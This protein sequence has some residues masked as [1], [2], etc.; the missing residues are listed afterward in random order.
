MTY[1]EHIL[2][3]SLAKFVNRIYYTKQDQPFKRQKVFPSPYI[4]LTFNLGEP[5]KFFEDGG[6][7]Q[8]K[9]YKYTMLYGVQQEYLLFENPAVVETITIEFKPFGLNQFVNIPLTKITNKVADINRVIP[10][11]KLLVGKLKDL[12]VQGKFKMVEEF[13]I[14]NFRNI[15]GEYNAV[16]KILNSLE[17]TNELDLKT[18]SKEL[19]ISKE[20]LNKL[21]KKY[22]GTT[23]AHINDVYKFNKVISAI[24]DNKNVV[25][26]DLLKLKNQ[27]EET[28]FSR[29]FEQFTGITIEEYTNFI[30]ANKDPSNLQ[31]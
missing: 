30:Q 19:S 17:N 22:T 25:W 16:I 15:S 23:I 20:N 24:K 29:N 3:T 18:I 2:P 7:K 28:L 26:A 14:S 6:L 1:Q 13:L 10:E 9:L 11:S 8:S 12:E 21:F 31:K 5:I 4:N 27:Y